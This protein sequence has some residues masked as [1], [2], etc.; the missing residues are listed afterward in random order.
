MWPP[1]FFTNHPSNRQS[2]IS[3]AEYLPHTCWLFSCRCTDSVSP[4]LFYSLLIANLPEPYPKLQRLLGKIPPNFSSVWLRPFTASNYVQRDTFGSSQLLL[5]FWT[6]AIRHLGIL[7]EKSHMACVQNCISRSKLGAMEA[8]VESHSCVHLH[9]S[10]KSFGT[11]LYL[12]AECGNGLRK[13]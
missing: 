12:C 1:W 6:I 3:S 7:Q 13:S 2:W 10:S 8:P 4:Y 9:L 5:R 11:Q